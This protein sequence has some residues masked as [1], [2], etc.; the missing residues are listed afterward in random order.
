MTQ[1]LLDCE[2][3]LMKQKTAFP[4]LNYHLSLVHAMRGNDLQSQRAFEN[5][6]NE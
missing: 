1:W 2:N 3:M 6:I 4:V 5:Y